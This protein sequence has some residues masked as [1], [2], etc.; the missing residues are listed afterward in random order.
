MLKAV[1]LSVTLLFLLPAV[2]SAHHNPTHKKCTALVTQVNQERTKPDLQI[3]YALCIIGRERSQRFAAA[4]FAWHN[5]D[6]AIRR[7]L[8]LT[9]KRCF[10]IGEV[11]GQ[12]SVQ[13]TYVSQYADRFAKLWKASPPHWAIINDNLYRRSGGSMTRGHGLMFTAFYTLKFC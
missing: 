1:V 2:A 4:G 11:I 3:L 13:Y 6:Y 10:W 8:E 12:T 9:G 7:V 5:I